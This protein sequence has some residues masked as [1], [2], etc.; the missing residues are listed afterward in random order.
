M[1]DFQTKMAYDPHGDESIFLEAVP[2]KLQCPICLR[3]VQ[4]DPHLTRCC[5]NHFCHT[6]IERVRSSGN[7]CPMCK[8]G[9]VDI[10]PNLQQK[11]DI[12]QIAVRCPQHLK[13]DG[14]CQWEGTFGQLREHVTKN[15]PDI[16]FMQEE[17]DHESDTSARPENYRSIHGLLRTIASG[18]ASPSGENVLCHCCLHFLSW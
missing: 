16:V 1:V 8:S 11:R 18:T 12:N 14:A 7:P 5:G 3:N 9:P 15:H 17:N 13:N 6:C 10:F 4:K 2:S